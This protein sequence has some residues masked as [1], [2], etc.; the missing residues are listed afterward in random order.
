M[1][2]LSSDLKRVIPRAVADHMADTTT[3]TTTMMPLEIGP[4]RYTVPHICC[5][6]CLHYI[7]QIGTMAVVEVGGL[8]EYYKGAVTLYW[9]LAIRGVS[10][11]T[12]IPRCHFHFHWYH[13]QGLR[14]GH[15]WFRCGG[16]RVEGRCWARTMVDLI[17]FWRI[18]VMG[19]VLSGDRWKVCRRQNSNFVLFISR[20]LLI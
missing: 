5:Y 2:W 9:G 16:R 3:A 10:I 7:I 11:F 17:D 19:V 4:V 15:C 13:C 18:K 1:V 6:W 8:V 12:R 20:N 14:T